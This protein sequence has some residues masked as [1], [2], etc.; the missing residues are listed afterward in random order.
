MKVKEEK[1]NYLLNLYP[2]L[3]SRW[4]DS[5]YIL[6]TKMMWCGPAAKVQESIVE[7]FLVQKGVFL[8]AQRP[9]LWAGKAALELWGRI[10]YILSSWGGGKD[11]RNSQKDFHML[12]KTY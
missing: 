6:G 10:D 7:M 2:G 9:D 4:E 8:K 12:K 11:K 1:R 3:E 5:G